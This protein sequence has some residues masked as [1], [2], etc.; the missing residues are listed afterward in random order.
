MLRE[1]DANLSELHKA[2]YDPRSKRERQHEMK[3]IQDVGCA[4]TT[5]WVLSYD[6]DGNHDID[7]SRP[8]SGHQ[9]SVPCT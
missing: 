6:S 9:D 2:K 1:R 5:A 7:P 3:R 4:F 8:I